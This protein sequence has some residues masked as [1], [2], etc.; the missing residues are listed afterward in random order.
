MKK[1]CILFICFLF[2]SCSIAIPASKE[3]I[4]DE[5]IP[6]SSKVTLSMFGDA[7]IHS[8]I[9]NDAYEEGRYNFDKMFT[10][11]KSTISSSDLLFYNQE[12]IIGG[13]SLGYSGYPRFNTPPEFGETMINLGFNIVSRAN[14]HTLDRGEPAILNSCNFWNRHPSVLTNG[15]AC[16]IEERNTPKIFEKNGIKYT[17]LSYTEMTNGLKAKENYHV[18]IYSDETVL[19][20]I[21]KI[22]NDVDLILVSM[23]WGNEYTT[24]PT[25]EQIRISKYLSSL[26]ANII[27][28][29]HPH[30]IEPIEWIG[31]TLVIYSLGN[32]ISNQKTVDDYARRIGL[33]V[34]VD[35]IKTITDHETRIT[36]DNLNTELIYTYSQNNKNFKVIPFSKMS[37]SYL[38]NYKNYQNKYNA[39]I[40]Y[41]DEHIRTN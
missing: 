14:N 8:P 35:I 5:F 2:C 31:N 29:T 23:H 28:G 33:M 1:I 20:D 19:N 24:I 34:N 9:Y 6:S 21:E 40:K 4:M 32:F 17:L 13:K 22:K 39:I 36:L 18:N 37:D 12:T 11:L 25:S 7:L 16:T 38:K 26:G 3:V 27:I 41:Y 15:S 30:V 10:E